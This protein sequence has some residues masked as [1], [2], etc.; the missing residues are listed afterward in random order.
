MMNR[1][2]SFLMMGVLL[3]GLFGTAFVTQNDEQE[4]KGYEYLTQTL[5]NTKSQT[6]GVINAMP[7][8]KFSYKPVDDVRTF[9][10][11]AF[12][13]AQAIDFFMANFQGQQFQPGETDENSMTKE[14]V[15]KYYSEQFDKITAY[16]M[17][18]EESGPLTAG[19]MFFLD[20]NA[21]H[22]G[23]M[24]TYLRLNGITPPQS[25]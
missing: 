9:G 4:A 19:I 10:A 22:R 6:L 20:H 8:D 3:L 11:Q 13:L 1:S 17:G 18:A 15:A 16:I 5:E 23:Q 12:H 21:N 7:A 2:G 25:Q 14:E 24:V